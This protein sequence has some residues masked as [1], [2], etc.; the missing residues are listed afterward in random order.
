MST[1]T[2]VISILIPVYKVEAYLQRCI[3]SVLAQDFEDWEMILVDDGSPDRCPEICDEAARKDDRIRVVHKENG[4][5]PSARLAGFEQAKGE[6]LVFLDSDD[7][8]LPNAL[9]SLYE[10]INKGYDVVRSR[11]LREN[12]QG[13]RWFEDY[14]RQED[15]SDENG[16]MISLIKNDISPY[17]HNAIYRANLFSPNTFLPLI[18]NGISVGEDW[19]VNFLISR[20]VRR[21]GF[22]GQP[23]CVY[24]IN[25]GSMIT[26]SIRAWSYAERVHRCLSHFDETLPE[27]INQMREM[28]SSLSKLQYFFMPEVPFNWAK[29]RELKKRVPIA[30]E[31][32]KD[33]IHIPSYYYRFI[34]NAPLYYIYSRMICFAKYVLK[35]KCH[36][37]KEIK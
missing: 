22:I 21:M 28:R 20:N 33:E 8:L 31:F 2:P 19:I 34:N 11:V 17:L 36:K 12:S 26:S 4:G 30:L 37:R 9:S 6:Y 18:E 14:K 25:G 27:S 24:C 10:K 15:I 23:T 7:Y 5:L 35:Q 13:T 1:K 16:Y 32:L 29:Y 3:D